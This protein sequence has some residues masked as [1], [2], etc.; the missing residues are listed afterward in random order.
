[1]VEHAESVPVQN[2]S[3][4]KSSAKSFLVFSFM[5]MIVLTFTVIQPIIPNDFFPYLRIGEEIL[6]TG[7]IPSTEFMTYTQ[8]GQPALYLYWLPSIILLWIYNLGGVLLTSLVDMLCVGIF[9]YLL[10]KGMRELNISALTTGLILALISLIAASYF[11]MRPQVLALP[12]F[13][14]TFWMLLRWQK[15]KNCFL[16][17]M[18]VV[19]MFWANLHGSFIVMFFLLVPAVIFGAGDRKRLLFFTILSLAATFINYYGVH[20]WLNMFSVVDSQSNQLFGIEWKPLMNQ[21]WQ[22]NIF[23]ALLLLVPL[24]AAFSEHKLKWIYWIWFLGFGWMALS[25]VRYVIWFLP[26]MAITLSYFLDPWVHKVAKDSNRFN[27]RVFNLILGFLLLIFPLLLLPGVRDLWWQKSPPAYNDSTPIKAVEWLKENPQLPDHL[28]TDFSFSTYL[29]YALPERKLFSTN[30]IE[31][32]T[33]AQFNDY[34][35]ISQAGYDWEDIAQKY[36][37]NLM[38]PSAQEQPDLIRAL[39]SSSHWSLVYQDDQAVV[40]SKLSY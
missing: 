6:R 17:L 30:R 26:I 20:L 2:S 34:F 18:P 12:L 4:P 9:F 27:S 23:F 8:Y 7:H 36:D 19:A 40:F 22:A 33:I 31:D 32:L 15:G 5:M 29:T 16:W 3:A 10:W 14:L 35:R 28:W 21:G 24:L 39:S 13:G 11:P 25:S 37:I 1:M 38:M